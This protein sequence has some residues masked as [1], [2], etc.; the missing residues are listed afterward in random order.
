MSKKSRQPKHHSLTIKSKVVL[1]R[2]V[3]ITNNSVKLEI[4]EEG[5]VTGKYNGT[6]FSTIENI[7]NQDGTSTWNGRFIQMTAGAT[8]WFQLVAAQLNP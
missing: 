8:W 3:E 5:T 7:S 6:Q 1:N 2:I 4:N